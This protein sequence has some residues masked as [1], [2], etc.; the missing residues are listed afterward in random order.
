VPT[1]YRR[2]TEG[3]ARRSRVQRFND[4]TLE[5]LIAL[6]RLLGL[7]GLLLCL[8]SVFALVWTGSLRWLATMVLALVVGF[9][10]GGL[11]FLTFGNEGW[12]HAPDD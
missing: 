1:V 3:E 12:R 4:N 2:A 11:G 6:L 8:G 10:A 7:L 9:L 5:Y